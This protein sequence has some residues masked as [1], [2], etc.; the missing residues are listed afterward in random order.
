MFPLL[1]IFHK[2]YPRW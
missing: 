1:G 2:G